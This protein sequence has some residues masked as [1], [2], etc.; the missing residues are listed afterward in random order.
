MN[1]DFSIECR[2]DDVRIEKM[3]FMPKFRQPTDRFS[4]V[5]INIAQAA[6]T[7]EAKIKYPEWLI[8]DF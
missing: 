8:P 5:I 2:F 7:L 3:N 4:N 6:E 1:G